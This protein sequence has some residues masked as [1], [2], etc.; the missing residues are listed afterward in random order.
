MINLDLQQIDHNQFSLKK[1]WSDSSDSSV[2]RVLV[3]WG[4]VYFLEFK[5][6]LRLVYKSGLFYMQVFSW[7]LYISAMKT[8][9]LS[10]Y[11]MPNFLFTCQVSTNNWLNFQFVVKQYKKNANWIWNSKTKIWNVVISH[12]KICR[13][14]LN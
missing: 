2:S 5:S 13:S 3:C 6:I 11:F 12:T 14:W 8:W 9:K 4:F 10:F 7:M 1:I